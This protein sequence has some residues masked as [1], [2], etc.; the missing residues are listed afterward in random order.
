MFFKVEYLKFYFW[1]VKHTQKNNNN[2]VK[3]DKID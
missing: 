2:N 1:E 3:S